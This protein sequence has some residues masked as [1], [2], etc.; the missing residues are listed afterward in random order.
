MLLGWYDKSTSE[1]MGDDNHALESH[2]HIV[3]STF[4]SMKRNEEIK[5]K[6]KRNKEEKR[7]RKGKIKEK[8]GYNENRVE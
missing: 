8:E 3:P 1:S 6:R 4:T 5:G 2:P 7:N